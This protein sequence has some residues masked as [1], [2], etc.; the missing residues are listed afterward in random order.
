[1]PFVPAPQIME[2]QFRTTWAGQQTMNRVHVN[3]LAPVTQLTCQNLANAGLTWWET[4]VTGITPTNLLLR[5]VYVK[6]LDSITPFQATAAPPAPLAGSFGQPSL[7]NN[8]AI[9]ASLRTGLAGRS[10][11]GRWYWQGLTEGV[12]FDNDVIAGHIASIDGAL[13][14]LGGTIVGLGFLW[15]IWSYISGGA[16]RVGGPVY[17]GV[18]DIIFVDSVVD[19]Q[20]RRLPG[21]GN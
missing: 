4:N 18:S 19:S 6:G 7:P 8:V 2:M 10:A 14:N 15:V 11:R 16:P 1:M 5:E 12:V 9:C 21:R 13:S 20:R 3:A 17:F